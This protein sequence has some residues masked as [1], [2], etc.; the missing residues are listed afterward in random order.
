MD[1]LWTCLKS[2]NNCA[3]LWDQKYSLSTQGECISVPE[4]LLGLELW[5][6]SNITEI[7]IR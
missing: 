3:F 6:V 1:S 7:I 5:C 4:A 2:V